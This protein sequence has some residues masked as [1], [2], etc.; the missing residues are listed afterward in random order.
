[1][2]CCFFM[3]VVGMPSMWVMRSFFLSPD[4]AAGVPGKTLVTRTVAL[5]GM[6]RIPMP[7]KPSRL[8]RCFLA[9]AAPA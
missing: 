8:A 3:P 1:M 5:V 7:P 2:T 4:R 9:S 6:K